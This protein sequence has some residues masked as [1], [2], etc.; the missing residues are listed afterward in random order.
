[1]NKKETKQP[2]SLEQK[3]LGLLRANARS[4]HVGE[5]RK[6]MMLDKKEHGQL[7]SQLGLM[8]AAGLVTELPGGKYRA[9]RKAPRGP[10]A[11]A[12]ADGV[13]PEQSKARP[14]LASR[15]DISQGG[16][17]LP[18]K[19]RNPFARGADG[20]DERGTRGKARF[21]SRSD[22][23][24]DERDLRDEARFADASE[25]NEA[26]ARTPRSTRSE[27]SDVERGPRGKGR[28][29]GRDDV[30]RGDEAGSRGNR[31]PAG[32]PGSGD[33]PSPRGKGRF[34]GRDDVARG[35][36]AGA[37]GNRRPAGRDDVAR[38]DEAGSR[39]KG[40][41]AG[42]DDADRGKGRFASRDDGDERGTRGFAGSSDSDGDDLAHDGEAFEAAD[43]G[44]DMS[45]RSD[46][47]GQQPFA[48]RADSERGGPKTRRRAERVARSRVAQFQTHAREPHKGKDRHSRDLPRGG[49]HGRPSHESADNRREDYGHR[50]PRGRAELVGRL[51][52][53]TRGFGF[54]TPEEP[55]PDIFIPP[56]A[57]GSAL[58]GDK[59]RVRVF[60]SPKGFDGQVLEVI[61]RA[62]HYIGGQLLML[63]YA[64]FIEA[65]DERLK[66]RVQVVG[67]LPENART[68][69]GV[70]AKVVGFP[71]QP[72]E[73]LL[74]TV[75]EAFDPAEFAEFEI[76]RIMLSQGVRDD[77]D[78]DVQAEARAYGDHVT[79]ADCEGRVDYRDLDLLTIDPDDARD[80]DDAVYAEP[81][82]AGGFRVIVAIADVSHYVRPDTALDREALARGCTIYLPSRAI[83]MLPRELSSH[84]AS[85]LPEVDRLALAVDLELDREGSVRKYKFVEC[86]M[87]SAARLSYGGVARALGMT[88]D[89]PV[90]PEAFSRKPQLELLLEVAKLLGAQRKRRGSLDFDLPEAKVKLNPET[91]EPVSIERSRTDPGVRSAY[92]LIEELMLLANEVVARDLSKRKVAAIYRVHGAPNEEKVMA[93]AELAGTMGFKIDDDIAEQPGKLARFLSTVVDPR[94]AEVLSYLLLRAMQQATYATDNIGHFGLAAEDYVHFTS[95]IRRYPDLAIHRIVRKI[96]RGE[97]LHGKKLKTE[98]AEQAAE[99][100]RLERRAMLIE[101][102]VVDLYRAMMMRDRVGDE[103]EGT[104]TGI[105]EHGLFVAIESPCVD[106]FCR[107][108]SLP[109]DQ[110]EADQFN[111]RL[112]GLA[113]G[114]A[115]ALFDRLAVRIEDVSIA[116][117]RISAVP[118]EV[119]SSP[120]P[121]Q[122]G[123]ASRMR[124]KPTKPPARGAGSHVQAS[125]KGRPGNER[126]P[127]RRSKESKR[128]DKGKSKGKG[129]RR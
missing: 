30:A 71:E 12:A 102:E 99:S 28:P 65:D 4:M 7:A 47:A 13:R 17:K 39:G 122:I 62:T 77:F 70:I 72:G 84:L 125:H 10:D 88:E 38:G 31:R 66:A 20:D 27:D 75:V 11:P 67:E 23:Q 120:A 96:A 123:G 126:D 78:E 117:R 100:S 40:R 107:L 68:G 45:P 111:T 24:D 127:R 32:A 57:L 36:E 112:V 105:T 2:K 101:R 90:Q 106:V 22:S 3:L 61:E 81:A 49:R 34:A 54:V 59:V 79:E 58:H 91:G 87:R 46:S 73:P 109:P 44:D 41:P 93:F 56:P 74:A 114:R 64:T 89:G 76:R 124:R 48:R 26:E 113:T 104:I 108:Q 8:A 92:N 95:P 69:Q 9:P 94:H 82:S 15:A 16:R 51:N 110:Y 19:G 98:L 29:T 35:D 85:L 33:E 18:S 6:L 116:R 118:V 50:S 83:P 80:H 55:G 14:A 52:V 43:G 60:P 129:K 1:V 86:V 42:R 115:F 121:Q 21:A 128:S 103:F 63:P 37:R 119:L 5:L 25:A 53:N 97:A